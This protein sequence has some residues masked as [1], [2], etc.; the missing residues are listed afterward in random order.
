MVVSLEPIPDVDARPLLVV[1]DGAMPLPN[2]AFDTYKTIVDLIGL[3]AGC[4]VIGGIA[5]D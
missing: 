2:G 5:Y 1:V 3:L 4:S